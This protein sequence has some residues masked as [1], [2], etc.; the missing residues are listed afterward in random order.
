MILNQGKESACTGFGLACVVNYLRW[1]K[2]DYPKKMDSVSPRMFYNFARRYDEYA[3]ENC[4]G[5]S[6]RGA[7]KGWFNHGVCME[8]DWPFSDHEIL[9]PKYGY[10]KNAINN[11]LGV[12]YR[13][14]MKSI[15]DMQAAIQSVGA[16]YVSAFTHT[17]WDGSSSTGEAL[18]AWRQA[19][20]DAG[21]GEPGRYTV[22]IGEK[23]ITA[24]PKS[25]IPAAHGSFDNDVD[26]ISTTLERIRRS[27]LLVAVDDLRGF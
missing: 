22:V 18:K 20:T 9:Q 12:Y 24:K 23:V 3:G 4:D 8:S 10:A 7:I 13:I 27:D 2:A 19:F 6:C 1:A 15:T 21:P 25:E 11:T 16:V 26:V 14:D 17:G 5:S